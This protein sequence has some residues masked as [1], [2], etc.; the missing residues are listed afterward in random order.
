MMTP[1]SDKIS[2]RKIAAGDISHYSPS[3]KESIG[4]VSGATERMQ[5]I[6]SCYEAGRDGFLAALGEAA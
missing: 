1:P 5:Q 4:T 6:T 3:S 2:L